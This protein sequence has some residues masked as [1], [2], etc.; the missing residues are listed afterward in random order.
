MNDEAPP[1]KINDPKQNSDT[2]ASP[3]PSIICQIIFSSYNV[4]VPYFGNL[5]QKKREKND[6]TL[7]GKNKIA[8]IGLCKPEIIWPISFAHGSA[9]S[10]A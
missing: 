5:Q 2:I 4:L 1:K 7:V 8:V 10:R 6:T 3:W 9:Q